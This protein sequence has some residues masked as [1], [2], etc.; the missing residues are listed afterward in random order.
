MSS[1]EVNL[2]AND[3]QIGWTYSV[4]EGFI[5][6]TTIFDN[7]LEITGQRTEQRDENG[8]LVFSNEFNVIQLYL[9]PALFDGVNV[10]SQYTTAS[11]DG[12]GNDLDLAG[13]YKETSSVY[14]V[15]ANGV[16]AFSFDYTFLDNG[17]F[18]VGSE[19]KDGLTTSFV[20][21]EQ[22]EWIVQ[23]KRAEVGSLDPITLVEDGNGNLVETLDAAWNGST[24]F[25]IPS[26]LLSSSA[27]AGA[28][29]TYK[30][31]QSWD[32]GSETTYFDAAGV[33]LG[34]V[35]RYL[36]LRVAATM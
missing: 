29:E 25:E 18:V 28:S 15:T 19:T 6:S 32:N 22:G 9:D 31:V 35:N 12:E 27:E 1:Y 36:D 10:Y 21:D 20:A 4:T 23:G 16:N 5:T 3:V 11:T 24:T 8:D 17:E 7:D 30:I 2:D 26:A 34:Y 13:A 33:I 14:E